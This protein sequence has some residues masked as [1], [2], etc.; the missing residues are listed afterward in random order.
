MTPRDAVKYGLT[1]LNAFCGLIVAYPGPEI[2]GLERVLC[3]ALIAGCG[4]TL[5]LIDPPRTA[6][7]KAADDRLSARQAKQVADELEAR[8]KAQGRG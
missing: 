1:F 5:L 7:R 2:G 3:A 6:K 8:M 4:T